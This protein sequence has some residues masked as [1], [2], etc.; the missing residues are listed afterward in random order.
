MLLEESET[1]NAELLQDEEAL[2]KA[3]AERIRPGLTMF[4]DGSRLGDG[5]TGYAVVWKRGLTWAVPKCT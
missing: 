2:A 5:A 1:L 3:E 4:T